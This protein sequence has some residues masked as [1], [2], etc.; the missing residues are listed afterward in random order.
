MQLVRYLVNWWHCPA[1]TSQLQYAAGSFH[2]V[3]A[4]TSAHVAQGHAELVDVELEP[5]RAE[6]LADK[7]L[8]K[9][10][11]AADVADAANIQAQAAHAAAELAADTNVQTPAAA[12]VAAA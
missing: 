2:P 8:D 1:G 10:V 3:G 7:A 5:A 6:Q 12:T 11:E 4:E 9:A